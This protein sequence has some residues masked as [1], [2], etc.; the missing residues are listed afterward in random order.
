[1]SNSAIDPHAR[2]LLNLAQTLN[3]YQQLLD[4]HTG[5]RFNLFSIIGSWE[6]THSNILAELLNP[7][8]S[9]GQGDVFLRHFLELLCGLTEQAKELE[10][11]NFSFDFGRVEVSTEFR[12]GYVTSDS[13][14][15]IDLLIREGD[16]ARI[17]IENKINAVEQPNQLKRYESYAQ[18]ATIVFLTLEGRK[19][20][21]VAGAAQPKKLICISYKDHI[22]DWLKK[23]LKEAVGAPPVRE[24]IAQYIG[25][26]KQI[27]HQTNSDNMSQEIINAALGS[28]DSL[29][30]FFSLT[31]ADGEVRKAIINKMYSQLDNVAQKHGLKFGDKPDLA[32]KGKQFT[33]EFCDQNF[34][35][36]KCQICFG[37]DGPDYSDFYLGFCD[38]EK[39]PAKDRDRLYESFTRKYGKSA[40][41][42]GAWP[43]WIYFRQYR[44]QYSRWSN[45]IFAKIYSGE[46]V[47][48]L[49]AELETLI[50]I[51]NDFSG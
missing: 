49:T 28:S 16:R 48:E 45:D 6:A 43:A 26:V 31:A 1:M 15:R 51:A 40:K 44:P 35:R 21:L 42:S 46:F 41:K 20:A 5:E 7:K 2:G 50:K 36:F 37:F 47:K 24:I 27:T 38:N 17:I 8:G 14:G 11:T 32:T 4:R 12:I 39:M 33:F 30:A 19:P 25:L 13:G 29:Q 34:S 9:H 23:C 10:T 3:H 18:D 22:L